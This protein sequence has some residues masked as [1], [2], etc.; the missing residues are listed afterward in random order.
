MRIVRCHAM[1]EDRSGSAGASRAHHNDSRDPDCEPPA[2]YRTPPDRT[3]DVPTPVRSN[4]AHTDGRPALPAGF[5]VIPGGDH[6]LKRIIMLVAL[7]AALVACSPSGS[8]SSPGTE[9]LA[10]IDSAAPSDSG[11][12]S[13]APSE[14]ASPS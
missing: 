7:G 9:T 12:E 1:R 13:E 10:P 14:S 5:A 11:M 2:T 4:A 3:T 8:A 6:M